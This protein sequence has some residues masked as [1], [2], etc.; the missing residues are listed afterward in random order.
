MAVAGVR[1]DQW[2]VAHGHAETRSRAQ[3]LIDTGLV[4]VRGQPCHKPSLAV[5]DGSQVEIRGESLPYVSRG[6]LKLERALE[7]FNL[8][9]AGL[10]SLVTNVF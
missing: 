7:A 8:D 9:V 4:W 5:T 3:W 10:K 2:L 6:G 1:L